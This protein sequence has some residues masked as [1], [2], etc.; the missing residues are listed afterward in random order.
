MYTYKNYFSKLFGDE[1]S[2][3]T[4]YDPRFAFPKLFLGR[5]SP[6]PHLFKEKISTH[7]DPNMTI[8]RDLH[9]MG[10]T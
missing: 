2:T 3:R 6:Y 5:L 1:D 4:E 7:E 10:I 8:P 9:F